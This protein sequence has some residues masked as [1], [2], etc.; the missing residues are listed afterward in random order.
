VTQSVLVDLANAL[1]HLEDHA[2]FDGR[3]WVASEPE[4]TSPSYPDD[5]RERIANLEETSLWLQSRNQL[6]SAV[7][8]AHTDIQRLPEVGA[9]NGTVAAHL[10]A[11]GISTVA[12]ETSMAGATNCSSHSL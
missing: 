10:H 11:Q 3:V 2:F 7:V 6:I 4:E 8:R 9:G 1:W 12:V 5:F